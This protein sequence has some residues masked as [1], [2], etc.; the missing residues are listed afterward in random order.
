LTL[1]RPIV[2]A[3]WISACTGML[4]ATLASGTANGADTG[5]PPPPGDYRSEPSVWSG[6]PRA[7]APGG[8]AGSDG[9][10]VAPSAGSSRM[11][12]LPDD[13]FNDTR[14]DYDAA[15]L[16]GAA[17][18]PGQIRPA[19]TPPELVEPPQQPRADDPAPPHFM[20]P[21][22]SARQDPGHT[23]LSMDFGRG[24][25]RPAVS[26]GYQRPGGHAYQGYPAYAPAYPGYRQYP[27]PYHPGQMTDYAPAPASQ[28]YPGYRAD[29]Y[30]PAGQQ[31]ESGMPT[32]DHYPGAPPVAPEY[33]PEEIFMPAA[34]PHPDTVESTVFRP[35]DR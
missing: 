26:Q 6:I 15:N 8:Q 33:A 7:P 34:T 5:Y 2:T 14:G 23:D 13:G 17:P 4:F 11:L 32:K 28:G 18:S 25:Q 30:A 27:G 21:A 35:M 16:F 12:P 9:G 19:Q 20:P 22:Y 10:R 31:S 3:A 24:S 29:L 1:H